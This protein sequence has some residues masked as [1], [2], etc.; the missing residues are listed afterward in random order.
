MSC[1]HASRCEVVNEDFSMRVNQ[2]GVSA[3]FNFMHLKYKVSNIA[4]DNLKQIISLQKRT[5]QQITPK[6]FLQL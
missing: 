5:I 2:K 6:L 3:N 4:S 1:A